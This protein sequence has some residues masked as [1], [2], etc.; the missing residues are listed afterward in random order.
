[1]VFQNDVSKFDIKNCGKEIIAT[2]PIQGQVLGL[3]KGI[4]SICISW[5]VLQNIP[6]V[7]LSLPA[8]QFLSA[9]VSPSLDIGWLNDV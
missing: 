7:T 6:Y 4:F 8:Y 2:L 1:M 3:Q 5:K 9:E